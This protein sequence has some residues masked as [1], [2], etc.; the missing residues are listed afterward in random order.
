MVTILSPRKRLAQ[1][2][3]HVRDQ[4]GLI[5]GQTRGQDGFNGLAHRLEWASPSVQSMAMVGSMAS[6]QTGVGMS[7]STLNGKG[8]FDDKH[9]STT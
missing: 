9:T 4:T 5:T 7:I 3:A 1:W 2:Q 6:T 8:W